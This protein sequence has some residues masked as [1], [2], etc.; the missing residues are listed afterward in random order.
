MQ[1]LTG[2]SLAEVIDRS[3]SLAFDYVR[4]TRSCP[5]LE[6]EQ[7]VR[8][9]IRRV[10]GNHDSGRDWLQFLRD[11]GV[12]E[13]PRSTFFEAL[14]SPR[15]LRM[16]QETAAGL[17][18]VA[19]GQIAD[20]GIDWLRDFPEL[21]GCE[22]LAADGHVIEHA[23]HAQK[24]AAERN[25]PVGT[26]YALDLRTGL[27]TVVTHVSGDGRR[28]HEM[29]S[30]REALRRRRR[31][32]PTI[33]V[34]DRAYH[35][36]VF[37]S[38]MWRERGVVM[39]TRMKQN[40]C[41]MHRCPMP[42]DRHDPVNAGV[43]GYHLI[44]LEGAWGSMFEVTYEDPESGE[45][46]AFLTSA[47]FPRPGLVAWLYF[48]RWRIEKLYDTLKNRLHEKKAWG[49]GAV[50]AQC[51]AVLITMSYNLLRLL[52]AQL[53]HQC[54]MTDTKV[55][56]KYD[57]QLDRRQEKA[58]QQGRALHPLLRLPRMP[59]LSAQFIRVVRNHLFTPKTIGALLA[60]FL[61]AFAAYL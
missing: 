53:A 14:Q 41:P 58:R 7:L 47:E 24:D 56:R 54:A 32:A 27:S 39:I 25:V 30:F 16:L 55:R 40:M 48:L 13:V 12:A 10:L 29:P 22:V 23:S 17:Q 21:A 37:W 61:T 38:R 51:Q 52:E 11:R 2:Q 18:Q 31:T 9:G 8:L 45:T 19:A 42:F 50:A 28:R 46:F 26:I 4:S 35:D 5:G 59:Q 57:E 44:G 6:D 43:T 36:K 60:V 20:S 33:W 49:C 34:L 1:T 15:R 3:L